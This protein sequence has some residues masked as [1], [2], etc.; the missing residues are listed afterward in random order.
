MITSM[1]N[2]STWYSTCKSNPQNTKKQLHKYL[3]SDSNF[4]FNEQYVFLDCA[5][6]CFH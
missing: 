1:H 3:L 5:S 2:K 6:L 4:N